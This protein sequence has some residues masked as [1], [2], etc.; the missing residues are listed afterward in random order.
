MFRHVL[1]CFEAQ[2]DHAH[3]ATV[4]DLLEADGTSRRARALH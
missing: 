4:A 2:P 1:A 3:R